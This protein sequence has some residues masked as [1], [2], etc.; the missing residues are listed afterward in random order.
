MCL[1]EI[2]LDQKHTE[3]SWQRTKNEEKGF[4]KQTN[5]TGYTWEAIIFAAYKIAFVLHNPKGDKM[6]NCQFV[7]YIETKETAVKNSVY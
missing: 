3:F 5:K 7:T 4:N 2:K 1:I 6:L